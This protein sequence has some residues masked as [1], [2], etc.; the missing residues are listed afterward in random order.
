MHLFRRFEK[1]PPLSPA[2]WILLGG[3]V[4]LSFLPVRSDPVGLLAWLTLIAP[5]GGALLG[6]RGVPLLPFGVTVPAG[7]AFALLW[8]DSL[9]ATDLPTPLW[10][11]VFLAGLFVCGLSLGHLAP[12]GAG[13]GIGAAGLFLFLGLFAS[14]LCVQ[15]GLGEGGASWARTHP[16][17]SRALL[18]VSPL[19]WAFDCAGWDWTHSQPEVYERSGVEWFGRRPYR[20]ILAGPLVLLVGC[21]LLLI[22][23][24]TQHARDRKRDDSPRPTPT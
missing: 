24:L 12:R 19:V 10:A 7:F 4:C 5:A 2:Q 1:N 8:S 23:R 16:G 21:A 17:L 20:G 11:S 3:L 18:E 13:A 9:S 14:G 6:A 15:G 22:V